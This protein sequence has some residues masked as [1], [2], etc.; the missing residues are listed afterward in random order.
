MQRTD[1]NH[2]SNLPSEILFEIFSY[3]PP[4]D[5]FSISSLNKSFNDSIKRFYQNKYK[6]HF[7]HHYDRFNSDQL[8]NINW[9]NEFIK[10]YNQDY[11]DL[12]PDQRLL[13]WY[14][15]EGNIEKLKGKIKLVDLLQKDSKHL[16]L[17]YWG[18]KNVSQ[19][20][21]DFFY[22]VAVDESKSDFE[23]SFLILW[24]IECRQ[25]ESIIDKLLTNTNPNFLEVRDPDNNT[26]LI[27]A[28]REGDKK[29][30]RKLLDLGANIN[31]KNASKENILINACRSGD[32]ELF[33]M[34][35]KHP[36]LQLLNQQS[37]SSPNTRIIA[38]AINSG[39]VE[40]V[41]L[42][43]TQDLKIEQKDLSLLLRFACINNELEMIKHLLNKY[44]EIAQGETG[45]EALL[46]AAGAGRVEIV[47]TLI[48]N[49]VNI[50]FRHTYDGATALFCA[51]ESGYQ[52]VVDILL[53]H[54]ADTSM[55]LFLE[56]KANIF[57]I[58]DTP[59]FAAIRLGHKEIVNSLLKKQEVIES[60]NV[61]NRNLMDAKTPLMVA[62]ETG[63]LEMVQFLLDH[64]AK[65][66]VRSL[67]N[68][69][70][71]HFAAKNG[72]ENIVKFLLEQGVGINDKSNSGATPLLFAAMNG[73]AA[74]VKLLLD[75]GANIN[76][77]DGS[78]VTALFAA[79]SSNH[80]DVVKVLLEYGADLTLTLSSRRL[81]YLD[82]TPLHAA[83]K[84]DNLEIVRLL[85][86]NGADIYASNTLGEMPLN[87]A[88]G[89][90]KKEIDIIDYYT[91]REKNKKD[92]K[93]SFTI[94]GYKFL[95]KPFTIFGHKFNISKVE[96]LQAAEALK[97]VVIGGAD[98]STLESHQDALNN[99]KLGSIYRGLQIK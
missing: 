36:K 45:G 21:L 9:L 64:G 78:G 6:L 63:N 92:Y 14:V 7:P 47:E 93:N 94:L 74:M 53:E 73:H 30:V 67:E 29:T 57:K 75:R 22:Q 68:M 59:L 48:A 85:L 70:A 56:H 61:L 96:K 91:K 35:L 88:K 38:A 71:L 31:V 17:L 11:K 69:T 18:K 8:P 46:I 84:L 58:G 77:Q 95:S 32:S 27:V 51:V 98:P 3:L 81:S 13:F 54:E 99:G 16:S 65:L 72:H 42:L 83:I 5:I 40:I 52:Q 79:I 97:S 39:N 89:R 41:R 82:G 90:I 50:N 43:L 34:L 60:L 37:D 19:R 25:S 26:P 1:L 62:A 12:S 44:P 10:A 86:K 55:G 80:V 28:T 15:K 33:E 20:M 4:K 2:L 66:D 76:A 23:K 87:L 24:A 49:G